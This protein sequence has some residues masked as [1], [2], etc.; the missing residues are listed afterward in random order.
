MNSSS[1]P[2]PLSSRLKRHQLPTNSGDVV[3]Y[4]MGDGKPLIMLHG[5]FGNH[6][7]W[8]KNIEFF[9]SNYRV[10][11]PD[12][13]GF[14]E[15]D[16]SPEHTIESLLI[17]LMSSLH[18]LIKPEDE[19][20]VLCFSFGGLVGSQLVIDRGYV[21]HLA[22]LGAV[23]HH[24]DRRPRGELINWK[25]AYNK[26][27]IPALYESM[28]HNLLMHMI[29]DESLIDANAV[30][31]QTR[32][33]TSCRFKSR[34]ISWSGGLFEKLE[35]IQTSSSTQ[36]LLIWGEHDVTG[37]P[38]LLAEISLARLAQVKVRVMFA[39][40]HWV[41]YEKAEEINQLLGEWLTLPPVKKYAS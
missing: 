4:E 1:K 24:V 36:I 7:H 33:C 22:I 6:L 35:K 9:A 27:D 11:I 12:M 13:P 25:D 19:I 26:Q 31:I 16:K 20:D 41:Q 15:S 8:E 10:L 34:E 39:A 38:K 23:G 29:Y 5:G 40:G 30:D 3:W 17:P 28:R 14:G 37:D 21:G 32:A 18:Q 2:H